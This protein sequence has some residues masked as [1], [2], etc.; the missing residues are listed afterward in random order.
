MIKCEYPTI[1]NTIA[2]PT[3]TQGM[4]RI[5]LSILLAM[6]KASALTFTSADLDAKS[7]QRPA[8]PF[9]PWDYGAIGVDADGRTLGAPGAECFVW[10][11]GPSA[12]I[13]AR[14]VSPQPTSA[15]IFRGVRYPLK[16]TTPIG[17]DIVLGIIEG[18]T[19]VWGAVW[20]GFGMVTNK[21]PSG[22]PPGFG[23]PATVDKVEPVSVAGAPIVALSGGPGGI[24]R[25]NEACLGTDTRPPSKRWA[26][27]TNCAVSMYGVGS[28]PK[29]KQAGSTF[30]YDIVGPEYSFTFGTP[31]SGDNPGAWT[32]DSGGGV[33]IRDPAGNWLLMGLMHAGGS[34]RGN[35]IE[36]AIANEPSFLNA[37]LC[38]KMGFAGRAGS[39]AWVRGYFADAPNLSAPIQIPVQPP[40]IQPPQ[41]ATPPVS[42]ITLTNTVSVP[43]YVTNVVTITNRIQS[44]LTTQQRQALESARTAL[45]WAMDV[46]SK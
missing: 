13:W 12:F 33:F 2:M 3:L 26:A 16:S 11:V 42:V 46:L 10:S 24:V 32:G 40:P 36:G 4:R 27:V 22:W 8:F 6:A 23:M 38:E 44:Y 30:E 21:V 45:Q 14:H 1:A 17:S 28:I 29:L 31:S 25:E 43:V 15:V 19:P 35:A 5:A 37:E 41:P 7:T 39:L 20:K 34:C 9:S 18:S